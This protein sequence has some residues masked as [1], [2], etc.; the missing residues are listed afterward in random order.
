[1]IKSLLPVLA[2]IMLSLT[3][4]GCGHKSGSDVPVAQTTTTT[5]QTSQ[6]S[7][8]VQGV[9]AGGNPISGTVT[10]C[11]S[12]TTAISVKTTAAGEFSIDTTGLK[13]PFILKSVDS[14][15]NEMFSF[16]DAPGTVNIN[17]LTT[18]SVAVASDVTDSASLRAWYD[19]YS[20]GTAPAM[21]TRQMMT[22]T[23]SVTASLQPLLASYGAATANP[24]T[25]PYSVNHQGLDDLFDKVVISLSS[26]TVVITRKD[27][28][29]SI[30]T[31][32]LNDLSTSAVNTSN[33]PLPAQYAAPG[34]AQLTLKVQGVLPQGSF[35]KNISFSIQLPSGVTVVTPQSN[36]ASLVNYMAIPVGSAVGSNIYPAPT[37]AA[38]NN[39]LQITMSS[40]TGFSTGDFLT[41]WYIDSSAY[42]L[43]KRTPS[44]FLISGSKIYSDIYKTQELFNLTIVPDSMSVQYKSHIL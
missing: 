38:T 10:L 33:I 4:S 41:I 15:N 25:D 30:V 43:N 21:T 24:F 36:P 7:I 20:E 6:A 16:A 8:A 23:A 35:I 2:F 44:D 18:L 17:P 27:T 3:I 11:D 32:P 34:N 1:M 19:H 39:I 5:G 26:G 37:L 28:N 29:T 42:Y 14:L 9:V 13:A 40:V 31:A 12:S 22:S